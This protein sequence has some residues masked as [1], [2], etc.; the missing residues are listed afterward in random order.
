MKVYRLKKNLK[1]VH[2]GTLFRLDYCGDLTSHGDVSMRIPFSVFDT[3]PGLFEE[4]FE[5]IPETP[6]TVYDLE[7]GDKC[8]LI[9]ATGW[10][11][12]PDEIEWSDCYEPDREIGDIF[13]TQEDANKEIERRKAREIL[14]RD[15]KGFKPD[16]K[17]EECV[18]F[19]AFDGS[20]RKFITDWDHTNVSDHI[21]FRTITDTEESIKNHEKEWKIYLGVKE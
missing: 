11:V 12:F 4:Y 14:R 7:D 16:W 17:K 5:E 10:N 21:Y 20:R 2:A 19:V 8:F 9:E 13:L 6:K 1:H 3:F 15:T 18:F